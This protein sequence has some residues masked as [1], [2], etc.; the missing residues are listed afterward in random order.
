METMKGNNMG[1]NARA[2]LLAARSP[3]MRKSGQPMISGFALSV[4][5][6]DLVLWQ[7][8]K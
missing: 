5:G 8:A 7:T 6:V 3:K 4:G 1:S 2:V